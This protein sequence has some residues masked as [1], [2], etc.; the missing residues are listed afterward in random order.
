M[1]ACTLAKRVQAHQ[2]KL[3]LCQINELLENPKLAELLNVLLNNIEQHET[4]LKLLRD[5]NVKMKEM[6]TKMYDKREQ[7]ISDELLGNKA[8]KGV[9]PD[10]MHYHLTSEKIIHLHVDDKKIKS[11]RRTKS[12]DMN[13]FDTYISSNHES[14][15]EPV[16]RLKY[17]ADS[18][19]TYVSEAGSANYEA[20]SVKQDIIVQD[21]LF[22]ANGIDIPICHSRMW[23]PPPQEET[24]PKH[25]RH[26]H[27]HKKHKQ[28][29]VTLSQG[30][31]ELN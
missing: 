15:V 9:E 16:A 11:K 2:T 29:H 25:R 1:M 18:F 7:H 27:P 26:S 3:S 21:K 13:T 28:P 31:R 22:T 5:E 20:G 24:T 4:T 23:V 17:E 8:L 6:L 12:A 30:I 19:E 14:L 10:D